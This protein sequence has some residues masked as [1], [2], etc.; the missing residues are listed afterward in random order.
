M[1]LYSDF[2]ARRTLQV[3]IDLLAVIAI[4]LAIVAGA[5]VR[6]AIDGLAGLGEQMQSTG[7]DFD[8]ALSDAGDQL[9][10]VPLIGGGIRSPFDAAASAGASLADAGA[11]QQSAVHTAAAVAGLLVTLIPIGFLL[12]YW[13]R[14]RIIFAIGSARARAILRLDD[15]LDVLALRALVAAPAADLRTASPRPANAWR[16]ADSADI[17]RLAAIELRTWGVRLPR[18]LARDPALAGRE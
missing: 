18:D 2:P 3:V 5:A 1:S 15:G 7:S 16:M 9:G 12:W 11:Q 10:G 13:L 17:A 14:A 4:V 8:G 6:S